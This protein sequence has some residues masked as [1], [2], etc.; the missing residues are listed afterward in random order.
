MVGMNGGSEAHS[1]D[2]REG[3]RGMSRLTER[4]GRLEQGSP[5]DSCWA[6]RRVGRGW[7]EGGKEAVKDGEVSKR[8]K[9]TRLGVSAEQRDV[10]WGG[11]GTLL[12]M[13]SFQE[14]AD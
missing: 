11:G 13:L 1:P 12:R 5:Q 8:V 2:P 14:S 7:E 9:Q 6:H 3:R 4:V 10:F